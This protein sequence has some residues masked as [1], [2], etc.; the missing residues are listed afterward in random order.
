MSVGVI[1]DRRHCDLGTCSS[2]NS[3]KSIVLNGGKASKLSAL[4]GVP[5]DAMSQFWIDWKT[6]SQ[7]TIPLVFN[8]DIADLP[9]EWKLQG[10]LNLVLERSRFQTRHSVIDTF[11]VECKAVCS[12][13]TP[14]P[15]RPQGLDPFVFHA[16]VSVE[17]V[18]GLYPVVDVVIKPRAVLENTLPIS[19]SVRTPM[20]HTY[21][22]I[23]VA[24]AGKEAVH[25]VGPKRT[26]E[27]YT[28]GPS[29]A[30]SM[31]CAESPV[32]GTS[33]DWMNGWIDLP[34]VSHF[35]I[36]EA[37]QCEF[38][39]ARNTPDP[40]SLAGSTGCEFF[41]ANGET[42]LVDSEDELR[43]GTA[44]S[45]KRNESDGVGI[46]VSA[47]PDRETDEW[48][49]FIVNVY[50]YGVDH[51]GDLLF[52]Q[53]E[54]STDSSFRRSN[55]DFVSHR[56]SL[57][58][59]HQVSPPVGAYSSST[60]QGRVSLLPRARTLIR[61]LHLTME[62]DEGI[63]RSHPFRVEDVAI[64]EGGVDSTPML[65]EDG[66]ASGLY[67]YR[68]LVSAYQSEVHIIP[69]YVVF[70]GSK[71]HTLRVKQPGGIEV[72]VGPG[73]IAPIRTNAR[74]TA[75]I[76][77]VYEDLDACTSPLRVDSL[78]L[79]I[80]IVKAS[81]GRPLGS[82]AMQTIVGSKDSR[83]VV[84][85]GE[86]KL[87]A[88][89]TAERVQKSTWLE[90]D[91]LRFRVQWTELRVTLDEGRPIVESKQ[92]FVESAM[93][94][95]REAASPQDTER[96]FRGLGQNRSPTTETWVDARNRRVAGLKMETDGDYNP[97]CTI[98]FSRFTVDWQ[99]VF[100]DEEPSLENRS[101]RDALR[102]PERSQ[103][104]IIVHNV[105]LRDEMPNT[106]YPVVFDSTSGVS[107]FDLCIRCRGPLDSELVKVDLFDLN[108][109]HEN[110]VSQR[111]FV[112]TS[113]EFV[114]R[115]LDLANRIVVAAGELA[116]V[117]MELKWDEEQEGYVV[118]FRDKESTNPDTGVKYTPPSS[119]RL[120]D[121]ARARVSPFTTIVSFKRTPQSSRYK[122]IKGVRGSHIMNYFTKRLKF[123]IDQAEL[124]FAR[125]EAQNIKGPPD[126]LLELL[127]TVYMSRAK[128]KLV[129]IMT[130]TSFQDWKSLSARDEGDDAFV[131]G[132]ILRAT[133][134]IA[135]NTA[136]YILRHAG[137]GIGQGVSNVTSTIGDGI[138]NVT[139]ALGVRALGAGVNSVVSGVGGGVA[140]TISGGT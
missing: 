79:R 16:R 77:V 136:N 19:L 14:C 22:E 39:F 15:S 105:Q 103:L 89:S 140:D 115:L 33:T 138:E 124:K 88:L 78:G 44:H 21:S 70:N 72:I 37:T 66:T 20:P 36:P 18:G 59:A 32:A 60:H 53:V 58:P 49:R 67:A 68:N 111:I 127:S 76:A 86:L 34:L 9:A 7:C 10:T 29:V 13:K 8:P 73:R 87:G 134:N 27:I 55:T 119:D 95:I 26:M 62:G 56:T 85:L 46:E 101:T 108:L 125:Y 83:L 69:E 129:T 45:A 31:R 5:F 51:L 113:E 137:R 35:R 30:V 57:Q 23:Y 43:R 41:V 135:G 65:W 97:V 40:L 121:I 98:V 90:K 71:S 133:G 1:R 96:Q 110:G 112:S 64:C 122:L 52:E 61:L 28:P 91:F 47:P 48:R 130:A 106:P 116:G 128:L 126:R 4:F 12:D 75:T 24:D 100:K 54:S 38:P 6:R 114:W 117:D 50:N 132:D 11:D 107:F 74:V 42:V 131:E 139:G 120:Y 104:S 2:S 94:R 3:R 109:A 81:D 80:A 82:L 92:A 102:S 123:K 63:K 118:S 84:K 17:L 99:R 93:D 25:Y